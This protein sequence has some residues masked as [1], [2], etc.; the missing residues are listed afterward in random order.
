MKIEIN[1]EDELAAFLKLHCPEFEK[2]IQ[3]S[4]LDKF[5]ELLSKAAEKARIGIWKPLPLKKLDV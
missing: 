1:F 5:L 3:R 2:D 4:A